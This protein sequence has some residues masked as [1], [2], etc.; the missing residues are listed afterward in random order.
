MREEFG[1][2]DGQN[3]T[4]GWKQRL[5]I[6]INPI[7]ASGGCYLEST[8]GQLS[9]DSLCGVNNCKRWQLLPGVIW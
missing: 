3:T 6:D 4:P 9:V 2:P 1:E 5:G 7:A 8:T